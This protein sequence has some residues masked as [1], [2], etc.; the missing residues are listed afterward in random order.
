MNQPDTKQ[1][2]AEV[3]ARC[4]SLFEKKLHDYGA[5]WRIM[6]PQSLTDQLYIKANRIRSIQLK[7]ESLV[8]E[9]II[10]EFIG[11]VNYGIIALIQ[12]NRPLVDEPDINEEEALKLY[13][14]YAAMTTDLLDKKN[15]D[16]GEAWRQMRV[17]SYVDLI[18]SKIYRTKQIEDLNGKTLVSEGIDA[19][20]M[21]MINY[22]IFALI[23]L[24]EC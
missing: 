23:Q 17:S 16:Y 4:R 9:G 24:G 5:A 14:V 1:Q 2:V 21:D 20:Y 8:G 13:D 11:I 19:N 6:R 3:I 15:H 12:L 7:G 10:P 22:A 18:L